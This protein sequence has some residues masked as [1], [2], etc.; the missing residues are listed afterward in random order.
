M[1]RSRRPFALLTLILFSVCLFCGC[2][3]PFLWEKKAEKE[4]RETV[5]AYLDSFISGNKNI[6]GTYVAG[7]V[8]PLNAIGDDPTHEA[9]SR[10]VRSRMTYEISEVYFS[11]DKNGADV[12]AYISFPDAQALYAADTAF[13]YDLDSFV[14][15]IGT[16]EQIN[17]YP[18]MFKLAYNE[19]SQIWEISSDNLSELFPHMDEFT[20]NG[21]VFREIADSEAFTAARAYFTRVQNEGYVPAVTSADNNLNDYIR[22][23][24]YGMEFDATYTLNEDNTKTVHMIITAPSAQELIDL[25]FSS[26]EESADYVAEMIVND[27][28]PDIPCDRNA[29]LT[30]IYYCLTGLVGEVGTDT[31]ELD[32]VVGIGPDGNLEIRNEDEL[33]S[34]A[35]R[36]SAFPTEF[37]DEAYDAAIRRL[38]QNG[39]LPA[40]EYAYITDPTE[41][42]VPTGPLNRVPS[43][44][45]VPEFAGDMTVIEGDSNNVFTYAFLDSTGTQ[46]YDFYTADDR[47][48]FRIQTNAFYDA[49]TVFYYN[50]YFNGE[51]LGESRPFAVTENFSDIVT[52][53]Y[54]QE[55]GL[56]AGQY[57]ITVFDPGADTVMVSAHIEVT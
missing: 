27:L 13:T 21:I 56:E 25:A 32:M 11:E 3:I 48:V 43:A 22:E 20:G 31:F 57:I 7:G 34:W 54:V 19:S 47:I 17:R 42:A 30:S 2:R 50:I 10:A 8:D 18:W 23:I 38:V 33:A 26:P 41:P 45:P 16:T 37:S 15:D 49:G 12:Q 52:A 4:I 44:I 51:M 1:R 9:I 24:I 40:D 14:A 6:S 28:D 36:Y 29:A 5:S 53:E 55:G 39:L 35:D 46:V